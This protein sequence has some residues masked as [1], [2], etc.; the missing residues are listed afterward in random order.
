VAS[1]F[2]SKL[3][4]LGFELPEWC[5][6]PSEQLV[7]EYE[8]RFDLTLPT[9]YREF[10]VYHGGVVGT[11]NCDFQEPTPCGTGTCINSFYGFTRADRHD[12]V[13]H[14]TELIDGAPDVVAIGD[15]LM[16]AMFWLKCS[17]RD[18]GNVYMHDH[19]GRSAWPDKMFSEMFPNLHSTIKEY[20]DLRKRGKLPNKAKGYE[21]VFRLAKSFS[22]FVDGLEKAEE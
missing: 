7:R 9:D 6:P 20:L 14:A 13:V 4:T 18:S 8:K 12:N 11:A 2:A 3:T 21:H 22:E 15:N 19:E 10:L 17:G 16:G 1:R 5:N